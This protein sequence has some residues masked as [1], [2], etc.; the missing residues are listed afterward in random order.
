MHILIVLASGSNRYQNLKGIIES[1]VSSPTVDP[2]MPSAMDDDNELKKNVVDAGA[3]DL[4]LHHCG[5]SNTEYRAFVKAYRGQCKMRQ[6]GCPPIVLF[7]GGDTSQAESLYA[8]DS[9]ICVLSYSAL[10]DKLAEFLRT[11]D[12]EG[13]LQL[14]LLRKPPTQIILPALAVLCQGHLAVHAAKVGWAVNA[15]CKVSQADAPVDTALQKMGWT[16][17]M[18]PKNPARAGLA[19]ALKGEDAET[20]N[21]LVDS[22]SDAGWWRD[23]FVGTEAY[24]TWKD[25]TKEYE[26]EWKAAMAV[27][28]MQSRVQALQEAR[29]QAKGLMEA[30]KCGNE[31]EADMVARAYLALAQVLGEA[32]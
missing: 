27:E 21:K 2:F 10:E 15:G 6:I 19:P 1:A 4:I 3:Y 13:R 20:L 14:D 25:V 23:V 8:G 32:T 26:E 30:I 31:I 28:K 18:D 11:R 24:A 17:L 29:T 12:T 16:T 9:G 22:V 7:S 5:S